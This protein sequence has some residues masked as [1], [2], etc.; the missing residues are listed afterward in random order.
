VATKGSSSPPPKRGVQ[1]PTIAF[2]FEHLEAA[3]VASITSNGVG[4]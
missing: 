2:D 4:S 1:E 3:A